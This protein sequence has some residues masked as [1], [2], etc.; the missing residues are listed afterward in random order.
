MKTNI[1]NHI[2]GNPHK[3]SMEP[4]KKTE[5]IYIKKLGGRFQPA[6]I[7]NTEGIY[8]KNWEADFGQELK[9]SQFFKDSLLYRVAEKVGGGAIDWVGGPSQDLS[10]ICHPLIGSARPPPPLTPPRHF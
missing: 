10:G 5:G 8:I 3:K 9:V 6:Q 7:F 1:L 4:T 2:L